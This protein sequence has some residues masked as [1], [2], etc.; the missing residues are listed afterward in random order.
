MI[1]LAIAG[2]AG[3]LG[4]TVLDLAGRTNSF[5]IVCGL[6]APAGSKSVQ[7][8]QAGDRRVPLRETLDEECDIL[9]DVS[10]PLGTSA[11]VDFCEHR[12]ISMVIGVT[13]H[14][15]KQMTRIQEAAHQIPILFAAN[16]SIGINAILQLLAP[17]MGQLGPGY[18]VEIVEAHHRGKVDAP[19]GTALAL[20][21]ELRRAAGQDSDRDSLVFGRQGQAGPRPIGEIGIHSVRMGDIVGQHEIHFSGPGE[22][23]TIRHAAHSRETFA[24]GALR[25]VQWIVGK[26]AGFYTMRD[27][28]AVASTPEPGIREPD[29]GI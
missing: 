17:L 28:L 9:L 15:D 3:R 16:F 19:S 26:G 21:E 5:E 8:I 29:P 11:W 12:E 14:S 25:A 7:F 23:V 4:R 6:V 20:A 22:T 27:V 2:A 18:D 1:R 10:V 24:A 13:G